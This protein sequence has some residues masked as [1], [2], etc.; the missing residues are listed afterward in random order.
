MKENLG[1][2]KVRVAVLLLTKREPATN[3]AKVF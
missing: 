3:D 2:D 1:V